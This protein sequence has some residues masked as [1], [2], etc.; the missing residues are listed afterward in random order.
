MSTIVLL[1]DIVPL[2]P[3]DQ[4]GIWHTVS[5]E[6][7]VL[8]HGAEDGCLEDWAERFVSSHPGCYVV[9]CHPRAAKLAHPNARVLG[10][11]NGQTTAYI[12][13]LV[14]SVAVVRSGRRVELY[15]GACVLSFEARGW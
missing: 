8:C 11:W 4:N 9:C 2:Y 1:T 15:Q 3:E 13:G 6:P 14:P 10:D 7:L 5:G 12:D